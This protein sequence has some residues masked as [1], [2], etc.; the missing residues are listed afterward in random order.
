MAYKQFLLTVSELR[1]SHHSIYTLCL[2]ICFITITD[3]FKT[4]TVALERNRDSW[5]H[6][7]TISI[8]VLLRLEQN[9]LAISEDTV[10]WFAHIPPYLKVTQALTRNKTEHLSSRLKNVLLV[11][12]SN[13]ANMKLLP[14]VQI[15]YPKLLFHSNQVLGFIRFNFSKITKTVTV[16][17]LSKTSSASIF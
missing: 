12:R 1:I 3:I 4:F 5:P 16:K 7:V 11:Q 13:S 14:V 15:H 17:L 8:A 10:F 2:L 9:G 6:S